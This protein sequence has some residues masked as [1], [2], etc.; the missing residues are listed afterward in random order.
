MDVHFPE[1]LIEVAIMDA[2]QSKPLRLSVLGK[3]EQVYPDA[4]MPEEELALY[5]ASMGEP[6]ATE[7]TDSALAA[8]LQTDEE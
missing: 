5:Q 7:E 6:S 1:T 8:K 2:M 4:S 3:D